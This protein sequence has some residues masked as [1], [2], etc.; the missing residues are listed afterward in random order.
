MNRVLYAMSA[1]CLLFVVA[2]QGRQVRAGSFSACEASYWAAPA[3]E[4]P[5]FV[6][7]SSNIDL[8]LSD[9]RFVA[10]GWRW[11]PGSTAWIAVL[12]RVD[13]LKTVA[14]ARIGGLYG[15]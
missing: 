10:E 11:S 2:T 4:A 12:V 6:G 3:T 13:L 9:A 8:I 14:L 15:P 5:A 1:C 7:D